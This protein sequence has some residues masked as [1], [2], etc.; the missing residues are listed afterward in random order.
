MSAGVEGEVLLRELRP[1]VVE[2]GFCGRCAVPV[3]RYAWRWPHE[4]A[5]A[6]YCSK[7][8]QKALQRKRRK[9]RGAPSPGK[10]RRRQ[11]DRALSD[12]TR[13]RVIWRDGG[14]CV[15]CGVR[16][17]LTVDHWRPAHRGGDTSLNNLV[18]MCHRDNNEKGG[19]DPEAMPRPRPFTYA[20]RS[21]RP[22]LTTTR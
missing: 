21:D 10:Q 12:A 18:T 15:V 3:T 20:I 2:N 9:T 8:C 11:I 13:E 1:R 22:W 7:Q 6:F 4:E 16:E 14:R 19:W 17:G 5:D